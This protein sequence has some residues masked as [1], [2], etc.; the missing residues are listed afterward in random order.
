MAFAKGKQSTD[1][2]EIK[3]YKGVGTVSVLA[4]NPTKDE[5]NKLTGG[6]MEK[7]PEYTS[8]G[9]D[10][11]KRARITLLVKPD[12]TKTVGGVEPIIPITFWFRK[13]AVQGSQSG[14]YQI[15][16]KYGETAWAT[17]E[18]IQSK[19]IPQYTNGPANIDADYRK[20]VNGEEAFT[21][22]L[23]AYLCIPS[24]R[25]MVNGAWVERADKSD[26]EARL[27]NIVKIFDGDF[28]E[29]KSILNAQPNNHVQVLF[30]VRTAEDGREYQD[31][32][33]QVFLTQSNYRR[34]AFA[35]EL[36]A[37]KNLGRYGNVDFG[38]ME[39]ISN[40][41]ECSLTPSV[42]QPSAAPIP[43]LQPEQEDDDLPF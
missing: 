20:I 4:V 13:A 23:K 8:I 18:E 2:V 12:P 34:T 26:C 10:G 14:K 28:K 3:R 41:Y 35:K 36:T 1:S 32:F 30:G 6:N 37:Q 31:F 39:N 42:V 21:K 7:E 9:E 29:I 11:I 16:D 27:D 33:T 5:W 17:Q 15:I 19:K 38:D 25:S 24:T 40:L 22:F 43:T